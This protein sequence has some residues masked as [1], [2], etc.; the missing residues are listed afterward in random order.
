MPNL[1]TLT[2]LNRL[3]NRPTAW[4][5]PLKLNLW[6]FHEY[7]WKLHDYLRNFQDFLQHKNTSFI[8]RSFLTQSKLKW[9][10]LKQSDDSYNF[11][12]FFDHLVI[13]WEHPLTAHHLTKEVKRRI[14]S[15]FRMER[16]QTWW[17]RGTFNTKSSPKIPFSAWSQILTSKSNVWETMR[18]FSL[19][20]KVSAYYRIAWLVCFGVSVTAFLSTLFFN[21]LVFFK[22]ANRKRMRSRA[23]W[24]QRS[25]DFFDE[26]ARFPWARSRL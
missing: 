17:F 19:I 6:N 9:C 4:I 3:K 26:R 1:R 20:Q 12:V 24:R 21:G 7:L 23:S 18:Y 16:H 25:Y 2:K 8:L 22:S 13:R 14:W 10:Y 15:H 11:S 5:D